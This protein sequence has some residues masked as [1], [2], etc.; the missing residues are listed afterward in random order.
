MKGKVMNELDRKV[1]EWCER[2]HL[3]RC[4]YRSKDSVEELQDHLYSE[5]EHLMTDGMNED[6]AFDA[7]TRKLGNIHDLE[8]EFSR[9]RSW[10]GRLSRNIALSECGVSKKERKMRMANSMIWAVLMIAS[11]L[12]LR[13]IDVD[14]G[15]VSAYLLIVV[16]V[17]LW[18]ASD[19]L[20]RKA[21]RKGAH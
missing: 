20:I 15:K 8:R 19:Q 21:A 3:D 6:A 2:I 9:N 4:W 7:A 14:A 11:A 5:I 13:N 10:L 17:P 16:F 18:F 12:V 1:A